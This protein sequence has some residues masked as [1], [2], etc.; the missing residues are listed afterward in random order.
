MGTK[1]IRA[2][3]CPFLVSFEDSDGWVD[4]LPWL[5]STVQDGWL[6]VY[7]MHWVGRLCQFTAFCFVL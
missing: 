7:I 5:C 1:V 4:Q 6:I 3:P 2:S